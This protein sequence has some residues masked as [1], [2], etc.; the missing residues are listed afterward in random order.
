MISLKSGQL[1]AAGA[2]YLPT[3]GIYTGYSYGKP[4]NNPFADEWND[5]ITVGARLQWSF[6]LGRKTASR[7]R[8]VGFELEA[9]R[10]S[11]DDLNE[12]IDRQVQLALEQ[13]RLAHRQY[14]SARRQFQI[15]SDNYRLATERH[16]AGALSSNRLLEIEADLTAAEARAAAAKADY[17]MARSNYLYATGDEKL[18]EGF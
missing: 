18:G 8:A 9:A 4:N 11:H 1:K 7:K 5:N 15:T 10:R 16:N 17:F 6:N 14:Q 12:S 13:L 3:L 2:D